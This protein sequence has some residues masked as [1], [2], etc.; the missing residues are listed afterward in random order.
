M[1]QILEN[2]ILNKLC[3][4]LSDGLLDFIFKPLL[5]VIKILNCLITFFYGKC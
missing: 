5:Q 3:V 2:V 1:Q 4:I